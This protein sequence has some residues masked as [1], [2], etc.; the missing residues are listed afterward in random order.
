MVYYSPIPPPD[1]SGTTGTMKSKNRSSL[2]RSSEH[3]TH[4]AALTSAAEKAYMGTAVVESVIVCAIAFTV[5]GLVE[6][7]VTTNTAKTKTVPVYLSIFILA[8]LFSCVY[9]F[10]AL[11]ARNVVQLCLHIFFEFCM[12]TYAIL[13]IPQTRNTFGHLD[14]DEA[15]VALANGGFDCIGPGSLYWLLERLMIVPPIVIGLSTII[16]I[17]LAV[18][19]YREYGW[20]V[21]KL[22]GAS[23]NLK[24]MHRHY[25]TLVSLLK[26]VTFFATA[27]C[28]AYLILVTSIHQNRA[29]FIITIVALPL[30]MLILLLCGWALRHENTPTMCVCLVFMV[31]GQAY[32]IYKFASMWIARTENLYINTKITMA[33]FAVFS[34]VILTTTFIY[35]CICMSNFHNG[36]R[37]LHMDPMN[38]TS[39]FSHVPKSKD[40]K[41]EKAAQD[42]LPLVIE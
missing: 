42:S 41:S 35:S 20:V 14:M 33:I 12:L 2:R 25:Q 34:I 39:V 19:L 17:I 15:C 9:S 4:E 27:F 37:D 40:K 5:F 1:A 3:G 24:R 21:F 22:V 16:Y 31:A 10:D 32:F 23:P 13:E 29:E 28:I 26:L 11:Y 6:T 8:R 7:R 36:L 30:S 18:R 38:Q